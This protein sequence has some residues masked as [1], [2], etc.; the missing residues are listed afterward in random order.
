MTTA[1]ETFPVLGLP[2]WDGCRGATM[3]GGTGS[4]THSLIHSYVAGDDRRTPPTLVFGQCT[5]R[6][7]H[8]PVLSNLLGSGRRSTQARVLGTEAFAAEVEGVAV[9]GIRRRWADS[10]LNE[11]RF[12]WRGGF[13]VAVASWERPLDE[14]F[15]ASLGVV[16]LAP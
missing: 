15:F 4:L 3:R 12:L 14:E 1:H 7:Q 9:E 6:S 16:D 11:A 13:H 10:R 8:A 5:E 2:E